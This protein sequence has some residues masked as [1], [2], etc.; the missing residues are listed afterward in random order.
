VVVFAAKVQRKYHIL[1]LFVESVRAHKA[2]GMP[3]KHWQTWCTIFLG[4]NVLG[5]KLM[6][7]LLSNEIPH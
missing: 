3:D 6:E 5:V 2:R 4:M 1:P 7:A